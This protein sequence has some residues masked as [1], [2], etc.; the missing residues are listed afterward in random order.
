MMDNTVPSAEIST[1]IRVMCRGLFSQSD[2]PVSVV[3]VPRLPR[4]AAVE[5]ELI[6]SRRSCCES[7]TWSTRH[8]HLEA[9]FVRRRCFVASASFSC[10]DDDDDGVSLNLQEM[11]ENVMFKKCQLDNASA[12]CINILA[13][14]VAST[15]TESSYKV[16]KHEIEA[17]FREKNIHQIKVSVVPPSTKTEISQLI[18]LPPME[19]FHI[20]PRLTT[21]LL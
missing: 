3:P 15:T 12:L 4:D 5:L 13:Y 2:L 11:I 10:D 7:L 9:S 14:V 18:P 6:T 20:M 19:C 16:L 8:V 21:L 17:S 1:S